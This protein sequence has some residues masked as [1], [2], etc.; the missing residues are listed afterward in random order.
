MSPS[1]V[2]MILRVD[3]VQYRWDPACFWDLS[4]PTRFDGSGPEAFGLPQPACDTVRTAG[5]VGSVA[6][7]GS[8]NC[9][10][11]RDLNPHTVT[12]LEGL[13]HITNA[14]DAIGEILPRFIYPAN[15]VSVR[16]QIRPGGDQCVDPGALGSIESAPG[17]FR[18]ACIVRVLQ[19]AP[20]GPG[21]DGAAPDAA[22]GPR[23]T[24][25]NPPYFLPAATARLRDLGAH[26]LLTDLPSLDR[27]DDPRLLAH[28]AFLLDDTGTMLP[29]RAIGEILT[30][31]PGVP[32]GIYL[33]QIAPLRWSLDAS[34]VR[35]LL[36]PLNT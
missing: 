25:R 13:G 11:V 23:F 21:R 20:L 22:V 1:R 33:L 5:F 24:G 17:A 9:R 30:I 29:G 14:G 34:P 3:G 32:D 6:E 4:F 12:H 28:R 16:P 27:E 19:S 35:P 26:I 36:Y 15:L 18:Q 8:V 2:E 10:T 7:G 31:P